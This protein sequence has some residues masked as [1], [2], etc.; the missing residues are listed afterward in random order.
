MV[1]H[2]CMYLAGILGTCPLALLVLIGNLTGL[3]GVLSPLSDF[4]SRS[5]SSCAP[6]TFFK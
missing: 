3:L 6:L 1:V 5:N 2:H 4:T